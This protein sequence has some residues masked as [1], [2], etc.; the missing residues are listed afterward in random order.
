MWTVENRAKYDWSE[1]HYPTDLTDKGM[2]RRSRMP[3]EAATG[4][5]SMR[6]PSQWPGAARSLSSG[7]HSLIM[8]SGTHARPGSC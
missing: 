6:S 7:G 5:P 3:S 4:G 2:V 8:I 1:L